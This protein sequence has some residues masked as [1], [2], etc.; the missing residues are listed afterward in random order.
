MRQH[1]LR[2]CATH[3]VE[4]FVTMTQRTIEKYKM[5]TPQDK[6]L[7]AVSGGKDSL[8][9]WDVLL[10][11]G[12]QAEGLYIGLGIDEGIEYAAKSLEFCRRFVA[13]RHPKAVLHVVDVGAE[14]GQTIPVLARTTQRGRGNPARSVAWSS[15][16]L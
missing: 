11:L 10:E 14:Y 3:F 12:Y 1:R 6:V 16:T 5:F 9:L 13:E 8:A 4:W 15:A 2:A 7:V